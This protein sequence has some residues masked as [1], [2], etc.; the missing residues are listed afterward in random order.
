M[1]TRSVCLVD[2]RLC[3]SAVFPPVIL[4]DSYLRSQPNVVFP[5]QLNDGR[6]SG[7]FNLLVQCIISGRN[8]VVCVLDMGFGMCN[9]RRDGRMVGDELY[10]GYDITVEDLL[11][12]DREAAAH[13]RIAFGV[14]GTDQDTVDREEEE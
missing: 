6:T 1:E 8:N 2:V 5:L 12:G 4:N 13:C 7:N 10:W 11:S 14:I 9:V 3:L